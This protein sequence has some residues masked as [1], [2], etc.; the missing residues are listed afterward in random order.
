MKV[1]GVKVE[2]SLY[3]RFDDIPGSISDNLK[4]AVEMYLNDT[5]NKP[6]TTHTSNSPLKHYDIV[7]E[8]VDAILKRLKANGVEV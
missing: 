4:K 7:T 8:E 5:V 6:L 1:L 2:D 3:D